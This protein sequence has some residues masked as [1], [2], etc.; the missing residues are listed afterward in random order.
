MFKV[1][2]LKLVFET[3]TKTPLSCGHPCFA[4][5]HIPQWE[6]RGVFEEDW[7]SGQT[8]IFRDKIIVRPL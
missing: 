8:I 5:R 6:K 2:S 4:D 7:V 3:E 1:Q